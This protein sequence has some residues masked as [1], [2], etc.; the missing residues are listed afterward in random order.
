MFLRSLGPFTNDV[1]QFFFRY[2]DPLSPSSFTTY[3]Y[4]C[5]VLANPLPLSA[6]IICECPL[7]LP[8]LSGG[9]HVFS[10]CDSFHEETER[11]KRPS[12]AACCVRLL[13]SLTSIPQEDK[14][15]HALS[16]KIRTL[17]SSCCSKQ[18]GDKNSLEKR[19]CT[20]KVGFH[21]VV[22]K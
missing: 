5:H 4:Y 8:L 13:L 2:F 22:E 16:R 12:A 20:V 17:K 14:Q 19:K 18:A 10:G 15:A 9:W 21:I 7:L 1:A 3:T 6:D 11:P